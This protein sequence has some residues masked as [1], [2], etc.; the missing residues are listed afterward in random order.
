M[1]HGRRKW[2]TPTIHISSLSWEQPFA[3]S[4]FRHCLC[5]SSSLIPS[6]PHAHPLLSMSCGRWKPSFSANHCSQQHWTWKSDLTEQEPNIWTSSYFSFIIS[7]DRSFLQTVKDQLFW[8]LISKP[9]IIEQT[10]GG[11]FLLLKVFVLIIQH[12]TETSRVNS[13]VNL[14]NLLASQF[15]TTTS[16]RWFLWNNYSLI[17]TWCIFHVVTLMTNF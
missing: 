16:R 13:W 12:T 8:C 17:P 3:F 10:L 11:A 14:L 7:S 15:E 9:L 2:A 1:P 5:L 4:S 6:D